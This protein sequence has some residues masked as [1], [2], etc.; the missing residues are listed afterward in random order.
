MEAENQPVHSDLE[1][2]QA[3]GSDPWSGP[4][5]FR[6][7]HI[8]LQLKASGLPCAASPQVLECSTAWQPVLHRVRA[9]GKPQCLT[10]S[11]SLDAKLPK[12]QVLKVWAPTCG[13]L[14]GG[15]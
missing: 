15:A 7:F 1:V 5:T 8:Q 6:A 3:S 4:P 12:T 14:G 11:Y 2:A 13:A 10:V 9:R